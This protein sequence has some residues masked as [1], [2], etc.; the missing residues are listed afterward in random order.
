MNV[1]V[2]LT[3][4]LLR[5]LD[6]KVGREYT[7]RSEVTRDAIRKMMHDELKLKARL[8]NLTIDELERTREDVAKGLI[9][10]KYR[11]YA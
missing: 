5:Y 10:G 8:K 1:S 2:E 4:D 7:S 3:K 9:K 6:C 11:E